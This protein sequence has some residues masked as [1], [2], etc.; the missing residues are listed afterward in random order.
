MVTIFD[1]INPDSFRFSYFTN[2]SRSKGERKELEI[3]QAR[4]T[5]G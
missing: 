5:A 1:T 3:N 2:T 4:W